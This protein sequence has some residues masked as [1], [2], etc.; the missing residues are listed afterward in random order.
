MDTSS[1]AP[2]KLKAAYPPNFGRIVKAI[3]RPPETA[4]YAWGDTIYI[5]SGQGNLP[6]HLIAHER[7]HF[8]QQ[9]AIGGP[10]V[11]WDRYLVDVQFRLDQ[12]V[13]AYRAQLASV[14]GA[15]RSKLMPVVARHLSSP[16]YGS[17]IS[18]GE[19]IRL[20]TA[21]SA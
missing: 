19:A 12:E 5:P 2:I 20:L 15:V 1:A 9:E 18:F 10:K 21:R 16:M 17:I 4:I 3:G 8:R 14:Q 6:H 11:W 7:V 13:E